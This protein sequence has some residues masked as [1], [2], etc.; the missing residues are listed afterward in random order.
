MLELKQIQ[1]HNLR[2]RS[3]PKREPMVTP[4]PEMVWTRE[5]RSSD[6]DGISERGDGETDDDSEH[7][8]QCRKKWRAE[9]ATDGGDDL[10]CESCKRTEWGDGA[11]SML[12]CDGCDR[13]FHCRCLDPP[14]DSVPKDAW[15][16]PKCVHEDN[17]DDED[18]EAFDG[19]RSDDDA[20]AQEELEQL[21]SAARRVSREQ[22]VEDRVFLCWSSPAQESFYPI[23]LREDVRK[24]ARSISC[25]CLQYF[26]HLLAAS[27]RQEG[28]IHHQS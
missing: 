11:G 20:D 8:T 13:R 23:R 25:T 17:E 15:W 24:G 5:D 10:A 2:K 9:E 27:S 18:S 12:L 19:G 14:L 6:E 16:C 22:L 21:R 7:E 1:K 3:R 28:V 26:M 4:L